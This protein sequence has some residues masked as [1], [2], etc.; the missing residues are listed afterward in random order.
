VLLLTLGDLGTR[1]H[2]HHRRQ[3]LLEPI[4]RCYERASTVAH[5]SDGRRLGARQQPQSGA[6]RNT[7]IRLRTTPQD[8][9][10]LGRLAHPKFRELVS[11]LGGGLQT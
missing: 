2:S 3:D 4:M 9:D 1:K 5:L 10:P 7:S 8:D 11:R 6:S